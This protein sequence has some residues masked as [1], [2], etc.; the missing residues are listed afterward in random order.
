MHFSQRNVLKAEIFNIVKIA[1]KAFSKY[2]SLYIKNN[3]FINKILIEFTKVKYNWFC[4]EYNVKCRF[5]NC[6]QL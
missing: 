4:K 3:K 2:I 5:M 1:G 6:Q